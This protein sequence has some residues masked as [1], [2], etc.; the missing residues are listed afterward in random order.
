VSAADTTARKAITRLG[1]SA[2][3][4]L[5]AF[6]AHHDLPGTQTML[7]LECR[8]EAHRGLL[9]VEAPFGVAAQLEVDVPPDGKWARPRQARDL[10]PGTTIPVRRQARS[11]RRPLSRERVKL[12]RFYLGDV[13]LSPT[14]GRLDLRRAPGRDAGFRLCFDFESDHGVHVQSLRE[15]GTVEPESTLPVEGDDRITMLRLYSRLIDSTEDDLGPRRRLVSAVL[16]GEPLDERR[17][18]G[19]VAELLIAHV[20]PELRE[21]AKRSGAPG[22]LV[23]RREAGG[24]RREEMY[25]TSADLLRRVQVL[26]PDRRAVFTPLGL[27]RASE[28]P[29]VSRTLAVVLGAGADPQPS[30]LQASR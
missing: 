12:D 3:R 2:R 18:P 1:E 22:E 13:A 26:P 19:Q 5:E 10:E 15:D 27:L 6:L 30:A 25:V 23:L 20:G 11:L 8:G 4:A 16:R 14:Y 9:N 7:R 28:G 21:I 29:D 24:G 17:W